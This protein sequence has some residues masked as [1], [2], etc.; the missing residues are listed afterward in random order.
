[1]HVMDYDDY[2][3]KD[4][5]T[6]M[7]MMWRFTLSCMEDILRMGKKGTRKIMMLLACFGVSWIDFGNIVLQ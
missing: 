1:M 6:S 5:A 7:T 4:G 3:Q 2:E